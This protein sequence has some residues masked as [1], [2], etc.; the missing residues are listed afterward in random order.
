MLLLKLAEEINELHLTPF[1]LLYVYFKVFSEIL[2]LTHKSPNPF[3]LKVWTPNQNILHRN[4][5]WIKT[6]DLKKQ[7]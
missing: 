6:L 4:Y 3:L 2:C 1:L 5:T 7:N